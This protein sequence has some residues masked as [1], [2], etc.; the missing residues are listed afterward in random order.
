[1]NPNNLPSLIVPPFPK[2]ASTNQEVLYTLANGTGGFVIVNTNDLVGG[3]EKI[4][5]EQDEYYILGY[6]PPESAEDSCHTIKVKVDRGGTVVRARTGYCNAKPRDF[7]AGNSTEKELETRAA[8]AAPGT[9]AASMQLP[10]FYTSSN[11][12]RVNVAMEIQSGSIKFEKTKGK[13]HAAVN[14]LGIAYKQDGSVAARFSDTVKLDFE[15]KKEMEAFEEQ[16]LHYENQFDIA[17]GTYNFKTV[18]S[19]GEKGFGKLEMPLVVDPYDR[20]QFGVSGLALSKQVHRVADMNMGVE[21]ALLDDRTP[22]VTKG[23]QVIPSGTSHFKKGDT[24]VLY[25]EMYEPL[26]LNP[27]P[28]PALT[29]AVQIRVLDRKTGEQKFDS[30]LGSL[31]DVLKAGNPVIPVGLQLPQNTLVA[32][33]YRLELNAQDSFGRSF[34]RSTDLDIE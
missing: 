4:G 8:A 11:T 23:L 30:G 9:V 16:P 20:K 13:F 27:T 5:K 33:A 24:I 1:M 17:S 34:K 3:L 19:S 32:G 15:N 21:A 31:A 29:V 18:F 10:Y 26:L 7:L 6:T 14:V 28:P 2:S 12:A 22:L 25:A